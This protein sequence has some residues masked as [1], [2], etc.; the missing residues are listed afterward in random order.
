[1]WDLWGRLQDK[2]EGETGDK[3]Q[4]FFSSLPFS[5]SPVSR[6]LPPGQRGDRFRQFVNIDRLRQV[7]LKSRREC[8]LAVFCACH[9]GESYRGY[10][11]ALLGFECS[12][13]SD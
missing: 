10:V 4:T 12:K 3:R 9:C 7:N 13:F 11:G 5:P 1:M 8:A 2:G 6:L